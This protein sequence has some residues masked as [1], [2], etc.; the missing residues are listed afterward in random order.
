MSD[1]RFQ[2]LCCIM[3]LVVALTSAIS[4]EDEVTYPFSWSDV[5]SSSSSSVPLG[6]KCKEVGVSEKQCKKF[7]CSC[8]C[9]V[10]AGKCDYG[11]CCDPECTSDEVQLFEDLEICA[12]EGP[13]KSEIEKCYSDKDQIGRASCRE[14]GWQSG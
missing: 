1:M 8:V 4:Y 7:E 6:C 12:N 3:A 13:E 9:N 14:R 11:C 5:G 2:C 10:M